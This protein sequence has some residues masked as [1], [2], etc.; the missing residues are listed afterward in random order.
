MTPAEIQLVIEAMFKVADKDG[1]T[2]PFKLN[3]AQ[4]ML[5]DSLTGRDIIPK[6]RQRGVTQYFLG[7]QLAKCLHMPNRRCLVMAH[8]SDSTQK[9]LGRVDFMLKHLPA[10]AQLKH[11]T[12]NFIE[13][14]STDSFIT[15][16]TAGSA[17]AGVSSTLTDL[18]GSEVSRWPNPQEILRGL[19]PAAERGEIA[20]ESTGKG[21][22]NLYHRMCIRARDGFGYKLHFLPWNEEPDYALPLTE[23]QR[24]ELLG[25]LDEEERQLLTRGLTLNQ[26]AW[27]RT[28][29]FE[30]DFDVQV[31]KENYP[32][33]LDECFQSRGSSFFSRINVGDAKRWIDEDG[34]PYVEGNR[35]QGRLYFLEGHP[36]PGMTYAAG[37]DVGAGVGKDN[38]VLEIFCLDTS[39]QVAE[40]AT[41]RE[42]PDVFAHSILRICARFGHPYLNP[43]ANNHGLVTIRELRAIYPL[44]RLHRNKV[45]QE[46]PH[47]ESQRLATFGTF[48]TEPRKILLIGRLRSYLAND[49]TIYSPLLKGELDTF[50]EKDSG[51]LEAEEGCHDDRVL[52]AGHSLMALEG[53]ARTRPIERMAQLKYVNPFLLDNIISEMEGRYGGSPSSSYPISSGVLH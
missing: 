37:A 9:L 22:G 18:L 50:I 41:N 2:V 30:F 21:V 6:A 49:F 14:K 31:F 43:E 36:K 38:S 13:F 25:T 51:K 46:V 42:E 5:H 52:A 48:L 17:D 33:T 4:Q 24:A 28:K 35:H 8:D 27:R 12:Q 32:L 26:I 23:A 45:P 11:R 15:V 10:P 40:Y 20:L 34:K 16:A 47:E 29:I 39:E 44:D 19:F 3:S 1:N 53:A 7:R